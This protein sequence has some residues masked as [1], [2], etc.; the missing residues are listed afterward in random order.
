MQFLCIICLQEELNVVLF[1]IRDVSGTQ[2]EVQKRLEVL[3]SESTK[4]VISFSH[5]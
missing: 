5:R 1:H 3:Q 2:K 4:D